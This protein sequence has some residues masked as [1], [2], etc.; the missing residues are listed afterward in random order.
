[1]EFKIGKQVVWKLFIIYLLLQPVMDALTALF[2]L[3][4]H[5]RITPG[6]ILRNGVL[7]IFIVYVFLA[8]K[9]NRKV[10]IVLFGFYAVH[11]MINMQYKQVFDMFEEI[12]YFFKYVYFIL[13]LLFLLDIIKGVGIR[14]K[15]EL[16]KYLNWVITL[17]SLCIIIAW[18]TNTGVQ[19]Y[20]SSKIGQIGWFF[21]G[22]KVSAALAI[23]FPISLLEAVT[24]SKTNNYY[25]ILVVLN[26]IAMF[27]T[28]TKTSYMGLGIALVG[29]MIILLLK[30]IWFKENNLTRNILIVFFLF[31]AVGIYTPFSPVYQN[32]SIHQSWEEETRPDL[33][34]NGREIKVSTAEDDFVH[35]NNY[36]KLFGIGYGGDYDIAS[37]MVPIERDFHEMFIY[38]GILGFIVMLYYPLKKVGSIVIYRL[39][40]WNE[41]DIPYDMLL[42]SFVS[43][44]GCS[45][46]AGHVLF[47][48][49][50]S[51]YLAAVIAL[52][53]PK[54]EWS[55]EDTSLL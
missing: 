9:D 14:G 29:M 39:K 54:G 7:L 34:F 52:I 50:V 6:L 55:G 31:I 33:I 19:S 43:A 30:K 42:I 22:T 16:I 13:C 49:S 5:W 12:S 53:Y 26:I 35:T 41:V 46:I 1:M 27:M 11:L 4:L 23:L 40:H 48:P 24:K 45:F 51:I 37:E 28:G 44:L 15:L 8:A 38:Y 3:Q 17:I 25:W 21:S 36:R 10:L 32:I 2:L 18:I 47:A 20:G